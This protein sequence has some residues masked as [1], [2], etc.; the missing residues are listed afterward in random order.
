MINEEELAEEYVD[1]MAEQYMGL[2]VQDKST[3]KPNETCKHD[4]DKH[5]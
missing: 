3:D 5:R 1:R 4:N 2:S